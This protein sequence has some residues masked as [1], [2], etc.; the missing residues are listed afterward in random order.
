MESFLYMML[1]E[2]GG[3]LAVSV[4][5]QTQERQESKPAEEGTS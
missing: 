5:K 3:L 1:F 4:L 2:A